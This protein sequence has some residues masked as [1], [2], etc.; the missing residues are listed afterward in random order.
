MSDTP[1][2]RAPIAPAKAAK[3]AQPP[4]PAGRRRLRLPIAAVLVAGFGSLML[5]AVASVLVL[6]LVSATTNTFALLNDKAD[7]ALAGVEVR[8]RHQL[9]PA[10]EMAR[11]VAGLVE[12]GDLRAGDTTAMIDTLRGALAGAPDVT[13]LA[14]I[15]P[16][17]TGVRVGRLNGD[18]IAEPFD[19]QGESDIPP[20]VLDGPNRSA[21]SWAD[22]RW[23]KEA[24][25]SFV[26]LYQPVRRDGRYLGQV[27]VGVSLGDLSRFLQVLYVEQGLNAFVLYDHSHVLAHPA[28][29]GRTFDFSGKLDGPPLPRIDQVDD[30][31]LAALWSS[32]VP[33]QS[34]KKRVEARGVRVLGSEY[35]FL[36]RKMAGYGQ[37]DW[38]IGIGYRDGEM[39]VE[40]RRLYVT[41]AVG[42][43]ILLVSVGVALLVGRRI[44]R[45]VARLAEAADRVRAFEFRAIPDLPDSRLREMA[46]AAAAFNAMIAGLRWF[47]TYVPKALVLRLMRQRETEGGLDSVQREVT[48][49]FTDIRGFSRMAEHMAAA[50]TAALLNEHFTLLAACIEAE[51][52]TVDKFIGDSLMAFWGAPE[53]QEDHAV[54]ALRAALAIHHA[55]RADNRR[56]VAAGRAPIHVRVGLH[57]G[58]VV[59]GNIGSDSRINYTIVGDTVNVAARIEELSA[60]LQGDAE[61]IVLTSGVTAAKG[62]DAVPLVRQGGRSL[63][64]RTGMTELW[65]LVLEEEKKDATKPAVPA[66]GVA[67]QAALP[68]PVVGEGVKP[69]FAGKDT[70]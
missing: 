69:A 28:L 58:P 57:S 61:V 63:R 52:G 24:Q 65:R 44:S 13:G 20:E 39:G 23:L 16:D 67:P 50:D 48:V 2:A 31:A 66:N 7:L 54:R 18:L 51:G 14:F 40:I 42:F 15:R 17:L 25:N 27:A 10:R 45:Q 4:K 70:P 68:S 55:I 1:S 38:I 3:P 34:L 43:A 21:A 60:A 47:E 35:M 41:G 49:M 56:R 9:D 29:V 32:G 26:T 30:P 8:V 5:A 59:V 6:G 53:A 37:Q 22:P 62:K 11:F 46:R 19:M 36:T 12:R 64:G 33:V